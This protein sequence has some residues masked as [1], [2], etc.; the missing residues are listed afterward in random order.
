MAIACGLFNNHKNFAVLSKDLFYTSK[1][2][3]RLCNYWIWVCVTNYIAD[4]SA[5]GPTKPIDY[6]A[7]SVNQTR[8]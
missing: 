6:L 2:K 5:L 8:L 7:V 4:K 1:N 3:D